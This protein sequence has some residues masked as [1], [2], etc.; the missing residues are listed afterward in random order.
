M[1]KN[2]SQNKSTSLRKIFTA[3][4]A[5]SSFLIENCVHC[6]HVFPSFQHLWNEDV[7]KLPGVICRNRWLWEERKGWDIRLL[8]QHSCSW[9][10]SRA[11]QNVNNI[12]CQLKSPALQAF[13]SLSNSLK[14]I[15]QY[16]SS[17]CTETQL[18]GN[19][20]HGGLCCNSEESDIGEIWFISCLYVRE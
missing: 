2:I 18:Y 13:S 9:L 3:P 7:R 17:D 1:I 12:K 19:H 11:G 6:I 14:E 8:Q 4:N 16:Q 5:K 10:G 20:E 15:L